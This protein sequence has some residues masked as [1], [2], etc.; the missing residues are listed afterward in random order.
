MTNIF[1]KYNPYEVKTEIRINDKPLKENSELLRKSQPG[2]RLQEWV[3]KLPELLYIETAD[4]QFFIVFHGTESDY[5]DLRTAFLSAH[6][7]DNGFYIESRRIPAKETKDREA[8]I[9]KIFQL[10]QAGPFQELCSREIIE[11]FQRARNKDFEMCVAATMSSGKSTLI[12]A[13]LHDKMMPSKQE[14][15]TAVITKIK[16]NDKPH[17]KAKFYQKK[18]D[19]SYQLFK[20]CDNISYHDIEEINNAAL[21]EKEKTEKSSFLIE[22]E[23]N[24]PFLSAEDLSLVIVDTPGPDNA[25]DTRHREVQEEYLNQNS[26][27]LVLYIMEPTFGNDSDDALLKKIADNMNSSAGK[28]ARDRFIF[29]LNKM[30]G[31]KE[32]DGDISDTLEEC[33]KYL[34]RHGIENPNIFPVSALSA[35]NIRLFQKGNSTAKM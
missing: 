16:D 20:S 6:D 21:R 25:R 8:E 2:I 3:G 10:V 30:D 24:V 34:K 5:D 13:L 11:A 7:K 4:K 31:R 19:S 28:Q 22:M 33:R 1:M 12:N 27:S 26:K 14:A 35:L 29:V 18:G 9:E 32:E 15:C 17:W 23:G